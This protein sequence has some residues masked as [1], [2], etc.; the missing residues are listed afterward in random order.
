MPYE[1]ARDLPRF[2]EMSQQLNALKLMRFLIPRDQRPNIGNLERQLNFLGDTVD[3]F[4]ATLGRR[5]WGST[6]VS[7]GGA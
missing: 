5:N 3:R 7:V 2:I 1:S 4:Y 6:A